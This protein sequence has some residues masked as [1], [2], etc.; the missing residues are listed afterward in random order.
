MIDSRVLLLLSA[1]RVRVRGR[2][3]ALTLPPL[4]LSST[5][6]TGF[7]VNAAKPAKYRPADDANRTSG[8][9]PSCPSTVPRV[10]PADLQRQH[11]CTVT[12]RLKTPTSTANTI[13]L[14]AMAT[15]AVCRLCTFDADRRNS[16]FGADQNTPVSG[17]SVYVPSPA[18]YQDLPLSVS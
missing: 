16:P 10:T 2:P 15:R 8:L 9:L 7:Y 17:S 4:F 3:H 11:R 1:G 18:R 13:T 6:R 14:G 12:H 5:D